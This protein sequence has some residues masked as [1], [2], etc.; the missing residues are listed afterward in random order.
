MAARIS[1]DNLRKDTKDS[2][3]DVAE[4]L[5]QCKDKFGRDAPLLAKDVYAI[6]CENYEKLDKAICL[7]RDFTYDFFGF[8]TLER[9][10]LLKGN[11]FFMKLT[12][13][14]SKDRSTC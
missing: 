9:A 3:K 8:K 13:K 11:F 14:S 5:Y 2:I 10:Y 4:Q 12:T 7:E 1:I 6:I